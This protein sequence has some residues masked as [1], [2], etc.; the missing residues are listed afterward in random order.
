[1]YIVEG[2]ALG[3]V[4]RENRLRIERGEIKFTP[5]VEDGKKQ[6]VTDTKEVKLAD[7]KKPKGG[8]GK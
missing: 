3:K 7:V 8:K 5:L 6:E 1:M 2:P 4:L